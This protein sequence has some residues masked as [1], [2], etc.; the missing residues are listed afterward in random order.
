MVVVVTAG[1]SQIPTGTKR[2]GAMIATGTNTIGVMATAGKTQIGRTTNGI[3]TAGTKTSGVD[4]Q[5][6]WHWDSEYRDESNSF[7]VTKAASNISNFQFVHYV[8][9]ATLTVRFATVLSETMHM[10]L[11]ASVG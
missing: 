1:A 6:Q 8:M 2:I 5:L 3:Q 11:S 9:L 4:Q 10:E 7:D